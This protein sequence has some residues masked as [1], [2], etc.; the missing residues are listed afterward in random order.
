L[1]YP[2][3]DVGQVNYLPGQETLTLFPGLPASLPWRAIQGAETFVMILFHISFIAQEVQNILKDTD[4]FLAGLQ[5]VYITKQE[6]FH[7]NR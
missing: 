1:Y 6:I 5:V 3:H 7:G 2:F 4:I